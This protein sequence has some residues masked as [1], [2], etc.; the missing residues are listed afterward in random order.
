MWVKKATFKNFGRHE[1]LEIELECG[2]V[3]LFGPNGCG[4]STVTDGIFACL[5]NDFSRFDGVKADN[6]CDTAE[7]DEESYIS[8]VA[9]HDSVEFELYRGLRPNSQ[10]LRIGGGQKIRKA[11]DIQTALEEQLG[12]PFKLLERFC[13]VP[14]W[15]MF[16]F[17]SATPG[18]RAK[19][20]QHMCGTARA[21]EIHDAVGE[22]LDRDADLVSDIED[23]SD[24]LRAELGELDTQ[25]HATEV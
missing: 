1:L 23:N 17:L 18:E 21:Q 24:D 20:F 11:S 8:I 6:I 19:A 3:G 15:A 16:A 12:V 13:F 2:L 9:E 10:W 22:L 4:K 5:T 14:Q 25:L 7:D